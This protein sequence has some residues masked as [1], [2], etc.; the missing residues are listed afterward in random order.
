[1]DN[2]ELPLTKKKR[3][4]AKGREVNLK[5]LKLQ[6]N[7]AL[8][9]RYAKQLRALVREMTSE[10]LKEVKKLFKTD[11]A[12]DYLKQQKQFAMDANIGSQARIV[13]NYLTDKFTR[14]FASKAK[15]ISTNMFEN[16]S[17]TSKSILH[18]S[19][20]QLSGG[21]SLKTGIVP[22]GYEDIASATVAENV[23]L[24]KSIPEKYL[25]D[26]TGS[27][28]RSITSGQGLADLVPEIQKYDGQT[29]RR[30]KNIALDQ[31]RKAYNTINKNRLV[32]LGV[33][34]FQWLHTKGSQSPRES[35]LH[36]L[37]GRTFAFANL[38]GQQAALGVPE[39]D[40][41]LP[42]YPVNCRCTILPV[43]DLSG[44]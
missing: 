20:K 12:K 6:H 23:S 15:S 30:A 21:L 1:M 8:E 14:L 36:I 3:E 4:W 44:D 18:S 39:R 37:D 29:Y 22:P 17:K 27:V 35:H 25:A 40:R 38:E 19:L 11:T 32:A 5:G 2:K 26:V 31:T 33:T 34:H 16:T 41:G 13:M 28:M 43:I 42:G 7:V 24:I 9:E 10:T